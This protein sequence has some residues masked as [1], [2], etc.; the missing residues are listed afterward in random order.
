MTAVKNQ[1][2]KDILPE[3]PNLAPTI[4]AINEGTINARK[5]TKIPRSNDTVRPTTRR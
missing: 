5:R 2:K 4:T 1:D 3:S